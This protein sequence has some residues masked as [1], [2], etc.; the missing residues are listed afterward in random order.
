MNPPEI[1]HFQDAS[2]LVEKAAAL[3]LDE[4]H[5]AST[6]NRLFSVALSGGRIAGNFFAALANHSRKRQVPLDKVDF[7]WADERNVPPTDDESNFALAARALF[8]PLGTPRARIH[9]IRGEVSTDMAAAEAEAE[10]SRLVPLN[11]EGQPV[12]DLV[13]LGM[14]ED[15]HIA[16]L[17]PG[18]PKEIIESQRV[19]R[20]VVGPKPPPGRVTLNYAPL[21]AARKVWV[22]IA[23]QSKEAALRRSLADPLSTP[24]ARLLELR[25]RVTV[26]TD[27]DV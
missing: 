21:K 6:T 1:V 13:H 8:T 2:A 23:G 4:A 10:I 25:D 9:R 17:F 7:F 16:S 11:E 26:F 14:G 3:F 24:L 18:E 5:A 22:F 20:P 15:G 12:L 19:Y 27:L